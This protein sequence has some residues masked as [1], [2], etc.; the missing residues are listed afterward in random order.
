M[1]SEL[2]P[3]ARVS[4]WRRRTNDRNAALTSAAVASRAKPKT[5]YKSGSAVVMIGRVRLVGGRP[6]RG[7]DHHR[8]DRLARPAK[9]M[10]ALAAQASS[11]IRLDA[12]RERG[13]RGERVLMAARDAVHHLP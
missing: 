5:A 13:G 10:S 11:V 4:G 3:G 12:S 7:R 1:F 8:H 9:G 6:S 2:V